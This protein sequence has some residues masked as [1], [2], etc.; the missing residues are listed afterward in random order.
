[1]AWNQGAAA[2]HSPPNT[3][4]VKAEADPG[5][6]QVEHGLLGRGGETEPVPL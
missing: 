6:V 4:Q 3:L 1:M 5:R 2:L